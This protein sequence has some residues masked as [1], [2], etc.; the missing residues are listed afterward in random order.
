MNKRMFTL[1]ELLVVIAIIGI[2]L[3]LLLPS[4]NKAREMTIR[5][6]CLSNLKQNGI[7]STQYASNNN[8]NLNPSSG[9]NNSTQSLFWLGSK[10]MKR[11]EGYIGD[12]KTTDC[13][14]WY[15]GWKKITKANGGKPKYKG[16]S[17]IGFIYSG[18][19]NDS[20]LKGP[21]A[22]FTAPQRLTDDNQLMLWADRLSSSSKYWTIMP[23][24][25]NGFKKVYRVGLFPNMAKWGSEG[26]SRLLLDNSAK[27]T[28]QNTMT[29][30]RADSK[31]RIANWWK[32]EEEK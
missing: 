7:A 12:W 32:V 26:G 25:S 14:N 8:R 24:T 2:L 17:Q 18:G 15:S 10:T 21:A 1:I 4:L 22:A 28:N 29:A 11:F 19:L 30:Q 13:P 27:W 9:P 5:A 16:T 23:H 31:A 20:K 3:S 6:V